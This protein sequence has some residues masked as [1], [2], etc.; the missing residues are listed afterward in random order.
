MR[1]DLV[2]RDEGDPPLEVTTLQQLLTHLD[3]HMGHVMLRMGPTSEAWRIQSMI[4]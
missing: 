1:I 2:E 3:K 4:G